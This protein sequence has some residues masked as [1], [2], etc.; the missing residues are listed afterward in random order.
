MK[1]VFL[2][3]LICLLL[4]AL[5]DAQQEPQYTQ[6]QFNSNLVINPAYAG[7]APCA[8]VGARYRNQWV[9][10]DGAPTTIGIIGEGKVLSDRLGVGLCLNRDAVGIDQTLGFDGNIAY[11]LPVS[12][13]GKI[14]FG[15]KAGASWMKSDYSKLVGVA[16]SDPLYG[17]VQNYTIPYIGLGIL[18]YTDKYYIGASSPRI[19]SF[20]ST[21]IRSKINAPHFFLYGGCKLAMDENLE[22]RPALL[23]KYQDK[24]PIEFDLAADLWYQDFI[25]VGLAYRTG[26]AINFMLKMKYKQLFFGYSYDMN[27]S[28]LQNY[29]HGTHE[30]F[31]GIEICNRKN[32]NDPTRN[33]NIRYF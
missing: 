28:G 11:H 17:T 29:N 21:S 31:L 13:T 3:A 2:I 32:D 27:I 6:N 4:P 30:V 24:A 19:L 8:S 23:V 14:S 12:E 15:F 20:E 5:A 1:N 7:S 33:K 10:Q 22:L 9:G 18:Y 16:P 26:D 25:G